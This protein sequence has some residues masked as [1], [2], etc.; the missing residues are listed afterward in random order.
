MILI[1]ICGRGGSK[2]VTGKNIRPVK[3]KPLIGYTI[4]IALEF[5]TRHNA[6]VAISTDS[7][8]ILTVARGFGVE[9]DYLRPLEL[10]QDD[11][12]KIPVIKDLLNYEERLINGEFEYLIDLDITSPLRTLDDLEM[13]LENFINDEN[14][15]TLF[16]VSQSRK[17]PYFNMVEQKDD[18]YYKIIKEPGFSV[19]YRQGAPVV[20]ELN[21]SF[22][23]YRRRFFH[24]E[25][26]SVITPQSLIYL[27]PGICIDIDDELDFMIVR[28]LIENDLARTI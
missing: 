14:A 1:T 4:E 21:A 10:A 13:A 23:I 18:G 25:F 5:A 16:S 6:K 19:L 11:T 20:Y 27:M 28:Y 17:N 12:G 22:Y 3:G 26:S 2:A 7:Y 15:I 8:D 9:T 24:E